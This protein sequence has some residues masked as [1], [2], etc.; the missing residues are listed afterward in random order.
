MKYRVNATVTISLSTVVEAKNK[1]EAQILAE[2][3]SLCSLGDPSRHNQT[4]ETC[5]CHSGE[6]DGIPQVTDIE[7]C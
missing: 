2:C 5:W 3:R 7:T 4:P 6:I 1:H